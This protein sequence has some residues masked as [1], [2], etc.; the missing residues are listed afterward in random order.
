M[1]NFPARVW[2]IACCAWLAAC[3]GGGG[4]GGGGPGGGA[5]D[6]SG[7]RSG[8][9]GGAA[10]DVT[11]GAAP[12]V[13]VSPENIA[14]GWQTSTPDLQGFDG[15][16]LESALQNL[17]ANGS[18]GIDGVVVVRNDRLV[19]EAYYNG[20]ARDTQHDMRSVTKSFTSAL[21]G[22]AL[23]QNLFSIDDPISQHVNGFENFSH[24]DDRKRSIRI[25]NLL[26]M[27]TGL[28][29]ND[30]VDTPGNETNIYR[31][32]D[33]IGYLLGVPMAA[34]P[35][36]VTSY[37]S[38]GV[39]VLGNILATRSGRKYE[40]FAATYLFT[41]LQFASVRMLH[42]PKGVTNAASAI[43]LRPRDAAKLGSLY[44]NEG[45]WNGAQVLPREW[46]VHSAESVTA[47]NGSGYGYLWWKNPFRVRGE[48]QEGMF[49]S[50]NGGNFIFV[51]PRE[52]LV[53]VIT[54]SNYNRNGPSFPF[55]R[56]TILATLRYASPFSRISSLK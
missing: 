20:Y 56:D 13:S 30:G 52:R 8:E 2:A 19:A 32:D 10:V 46:V 44:L 33:W 9:D 23:S 45:Q 31:H 29:C 53:V 37:C 41:P 54:A 28:D 11:P 21:T 27:Q 4:G 49:A 55:V 50:G 6:G 34:A 12:L 36:E 1:K 3:G 48:M 26:H 24:M 40:D 25:R 15:A 16:A 39:I 7:F 47:I 51:L 38:G 18:G 14:D 35:G 42:S 5:S 22:I 17:R 43:Q